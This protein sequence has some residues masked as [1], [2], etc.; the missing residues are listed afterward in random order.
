MPHSDPRSTS[1][2]PSEH[3]HSRQIPAET[4]INC[5]KLLAN[6]EM[7]WPSDL[8]DE[9]QAELLAKVRSFRRTRLVK[10]IASQIAADIAQEQ[11][12]TSGD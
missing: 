9:Q 4:L 3:K 10:L 5:A 1:A 8:S 2:R 7:D 6:G 12:P 11:R